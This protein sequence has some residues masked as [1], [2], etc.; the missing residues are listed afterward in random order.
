MKKIIF[1]GISMLVL[2]TGCNNFNNT[3]TKQVEMMLA[4]YQTLNEDV[5]DD[6]DKV[7][8]D[9]TALQGEQKEIY[10]DLMK[11][12][13]KGLI[14]DVKN[15]KID[16]DEAIVTVEIDVMDYTKTM[17]SANNYLSEHPE[18][19]QNADGKLD[20]K[21]FMDYRLKKLKETKDRVKYTLE[22]RVTKKNDKW[23]VD[24]LT[25]EQEQKLHGIYQY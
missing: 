22:V 2:L 9:E 3:P 1:I 8:E 24:N 14:Y 21:K 6:L 17:L 18:E 15:E 7:V 25:E 16:G 23:I 19:F 13:Y 10:R 5:L 12:H 20:E 11:K 4:D